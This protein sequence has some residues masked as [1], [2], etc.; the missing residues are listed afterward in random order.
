MKKGGGR[1]EKRN[2]R[3]RETMGVEGR[4]VF[5]RRRLRF[6][7]QIRVKGQWLRDRG[8]AACDF[9]PLAP[10]C[11]GLARLGSEASPSY[12]SAGAGCAALPI[13][14]QD[15]GRAPTA[16]TISRG[17]GLRGERQPPEPLRPLGHSW[18][19][20]GRAVQED[21]PGP[22]RISTHQGVDFTLIYG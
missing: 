12:L 18:A 20:R 9:L 4:A 10:L 5:S 19:E 15:Y 2:P 13:N 17:S 6:A 14:L 21:G 1:K 3:R 16:G 11:P 8:I 7:E 22:R